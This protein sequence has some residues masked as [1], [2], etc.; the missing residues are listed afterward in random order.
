M[1]EG[2]SD[3]MMILIYGNKGNKRRKIY[4]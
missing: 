3:L 4:A 2:K 1:D